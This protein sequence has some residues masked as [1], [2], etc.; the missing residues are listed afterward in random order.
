MTL[1]RRHLFRSFPLLLL[2]LAATTSAR[3]ADN[4]LKVIPG[5]ALAWGAVNHMNEASDKIQK[6]ADHRSGPAVSVLEEIKKE[7][8]VQKGLDEKGAAGFFVLPGKTEKDAVMR[9]SLS[10]LRTRRSFSAISRS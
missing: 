2:A 7:S 1:T 8:G 4:Y 5:T 10:P 9:P 6:L 3:A